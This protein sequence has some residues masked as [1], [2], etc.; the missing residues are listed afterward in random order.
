MKKDGLVKCSSIWRKARAW[1]I[2]SLLDVTTSSNAA[3]E[4]PAGP[5]VL[6]SARWRLYS[7]D[8]GE[9]DEGRTDCFP[10]QIRRHRSLVMDR[11]AP[12]RSI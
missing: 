11:L 1:L 5:W 10:E 4:F 12:T 3:V 8:V 9:M 2:I 6:I 7:S